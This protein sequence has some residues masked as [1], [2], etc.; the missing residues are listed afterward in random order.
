MR[1]M[2]DITMCL[3]APDLPVLWDYKMWNTR[4]VA[5]DVSPKWLAHNIASVVA[6]APNGR[7]GALIFNCHGIVTPDQEFV[8]LG[9]GTGISYEDLKYFAIP[10]LRMR[11]D[12]IQITACG[13]ARG[14][15]G[16]AFC[17]ELAMRALTYV[18][19]GESDQTI[20]PSVAAKLQ[21]GWIDDY[22]GVVHTYG[23][24]GQEVKPFTNA[25]TAVNP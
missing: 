5:Q 17:K 11:V 13:A 20:P 12:E 24:S 16:K 25:S 4:L 19:A 3:N 2:P 18:T 15:T 7:L 1:K 23:P 22:E 21:P 10:D 9:L 6:G 14:E 8:K